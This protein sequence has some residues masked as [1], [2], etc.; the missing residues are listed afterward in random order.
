MKRYSTSLVIREMK[1]KTMRYHLTPTRMAKIKKSD[2]N[3]HYRGFRKIQKVFWHCYHYLP[4]IPVGEL[5][6]IPFF[7]M[8]F[9]YCLPFTFVFCYLSFL[10]GCLGDEEVGEFGGWP[11]F[12]VS[13]RQHFLIPQGMPPSPTGTV[14][15]LY[16][17]M[18]LSQA[19]IDIFS[20]AS[21]TVRFS[22]LIAQKTLLW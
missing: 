11:V 3:K 17:M 7:Y 18:G 22:S 15:R 6:K 16:R 10:D 5:C 8:N 20:R 4:R 2:N 21:S 9:K 19:D 12:C 14:S 13:W 1:I